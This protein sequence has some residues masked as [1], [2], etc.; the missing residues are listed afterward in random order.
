MREIL[1]RG[2]KLWTEEWI[3][4]GYFKHINRQPHPAGDRIR[5]KDIDHLIIQ[6]GFADWGLPRGIVA[7]EVDPETVG[8]WIGLVDIEGTKIFEGDI[9][10]IRYDDVLH[11]HLRHYRSVKWFG[12]R[13]RP[14]FDFSD[15]T[16]LD[17]GH[18]MIWSQV[19]EK[20]YYRVVGN[21]YDNPEILENKEENDAL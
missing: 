17:R 20:A 2:K 8:Q 16:K 13:G 6:D 3:T 12:E 18:Q 1:F 11:D 21:I 7:D 9:L 5:L 4:G 10:E 19:V 15:S 14:V